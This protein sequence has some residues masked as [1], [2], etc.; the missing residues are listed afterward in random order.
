MKNKSRWILTGLLLLI[1]GFTAIVLQL[2]GV[3]WAFLHFLD[4]VGG[5]F[6]FV[7]KVLMVMAGILLI[8]IARTDWEQEKRNVLEDEE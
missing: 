6:A 5:L 2:V 1:F 7:V 3:S 4:Q 8:V